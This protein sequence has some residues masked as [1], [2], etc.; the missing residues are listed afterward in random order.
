M[1][2]AIHPSAVIHVRYQHKVVRTP[3]L[4]AVTSFMLLVAICTMVLTVLLMMT[5]LD[6][7]SAFSAVAACINVLGPGFGE[8]SSNF[9]PVTDTGTWLLTFAMI[10]GRLEYFTVLTL[11]LPKFWRD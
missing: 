11:L 1:L 4:A 8:V 2:Q 5:G 9:I 7:F 3:V 10:L 6:F